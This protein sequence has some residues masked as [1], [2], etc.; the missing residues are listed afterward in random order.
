MSGSFAFKVQSTNVDVCP[1]RNGKY[2]ADRHESSR[3]TAHKTPYKNGEKRPYLP[4]YDTAG[5]MCNIVK[6]HT[7]YTVQCGTL[8]Y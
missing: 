7:M 5:C 4:R 3:M 1:Y 8:L 6:L 2:D